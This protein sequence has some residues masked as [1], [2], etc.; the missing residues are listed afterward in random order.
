[1]RR[2]SNWGTVCCVAV[3]GACAS[4]SA[5]VG[6]TDDVAVVGAGNLRI[7]QNDDAKVTQLSFPVARVWA[8]LPSVFDSLAIPLTELD[9]AKHAIGN[10]GMK[11]H[12][13]L[14]KTSLAKYIDCGSTQGFPSA[15]SYDIQLSVLTTVSANGTDGSTV[16][17]LLE[18]AGRPMSVAG[19]YTKCSTSGALE[20]R[21][22]ELLRARLQR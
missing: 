1:M 6:R 17:T 2:R 16:T 8:V 7:R 11:A 20:N 15:E 21:I 18:A 4:S 5:S 19:G 3:L 9:A 12:K 14:G 22:I 13:S 10:S